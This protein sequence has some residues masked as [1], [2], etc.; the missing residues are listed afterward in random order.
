[1]Y[2]T[3][4][5]GKNFGYS[6]P[7]SSGKQYRVVLHLAEIYFTQANK[8]V[9]DVKLEGTRVLDNYDIFAKVGAN[10]ATTET[11]TVTVADDALNLDFSSLTA[12]GGLNNAKI[13]AL[14]VYAVDAGAILFLRLMPG[15]T[16]PS[17]CLL[18]AWFC[19]GQARMSMVRLRVMPGARLVDRV[20]PS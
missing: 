16:R 2:Q 18:T 20:R 11:F 8:R 12:D 17:P 13:A 19:K 7:V 3:E 5:S 4:R 9:F 6:F 15:M 1:M 10:T 14:E